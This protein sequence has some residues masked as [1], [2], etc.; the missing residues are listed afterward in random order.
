MCHLFEFFCLF[1]NWFCCAS[2]PGSEKMRVYFQFLVN[3]QVKF[4]TLQ[5]LSGLRQRVKGTSGKASWVEDGFSWG[6]CCSSVDETV[7]CVPLRH[8]SLASPCWL[9]SSR[10]WVFSLTAAFISA[11]LRPVTEYH[12]CYWVTCGLCVTWESP[13]GTPIPLWMPAGPKLAPRRVLMHS[14]AHVLFA[15]SLD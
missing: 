13:F 15:S 5:L 7:L 11:L 10:I 8:V 2:S 3:S 6:F 9:A 14:A 12:S 4:L 1:P